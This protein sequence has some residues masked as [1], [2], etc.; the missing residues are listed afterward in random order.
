[1]NFFNKRKKV[2]AVYTLTGKAVNSYTNTAFTAPVNFTAKTMKY[3]S[4]QKRTAKQLPKKIE[5][6]NYFSASLEVVTALE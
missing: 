1:M 6:K 4:L 2:T 5:K 3:T